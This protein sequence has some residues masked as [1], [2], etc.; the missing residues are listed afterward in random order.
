MKTGNKIND[1]WE[2]LKKYRNKLPSI[3]KK[4]KIKDMQLAMLTILSQNHATSIDN[5]NLKNKEEVESGKSKAKDMELKYLQEMIAV[6]DQVISQAKKQLHTHHKM[7]L[8]IEEQDLET[9]EEVQKRMKISFPSI[10]YSNIALGN[11]VKTRNKSVNVRIESKAIDHSASETSIPTV[12]SNKK[13]IASTLKPLRPIVKKNNYVKSNLRY[14]RGTA[15]NSTFKN[16]TNN[17]SSLP[18][19]SINHLE[20]PKLTNKPSIAMKR[21]PKKPYLRVRGTRKLFNRAPS[22]SGA[23]ITSERTTTSLPHLVKSDTEAISKKQPISYSNAIK[24][25]KNKKEIKPK[26]R[27]RLDRFK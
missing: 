1:T 4:K 10:S 8:I 15:T 22:P 11:T 27:M 24:Q 6:R 25:M 18:R 7:E 9:A 26:D 3:M 13:T 16:K 17:A 20:K 2:N 12:V 14:T 21:H 23:S 5:I 19:L